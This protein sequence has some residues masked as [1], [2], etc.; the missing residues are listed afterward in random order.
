MKTATQP[1]APHHGG[2][3]RV[4][5][6][7]GKIRRHSHPPR[8]DSVSKSPSISPLSSPGAPNTSSTCPIPHI[9]CHH[10]HSGRS[11][12]RGSA[13]EEQERIHDLELWNTAYDALKRDSRAAGLVLAYESII[14]HGLP[15]TLRPGHYGN[16]NGLPAE[17]DKRL[18]LM[19]MIA[20]SGL[21]REVTPASKADSGD[22]DAREILVEARATIA[23]LVT[24]Q[25]SVS[26]AWSGICSLTPL[27]LD[28][29][30][31]H[32]DLR[33]GFVHLTDT[34]PHYMTLP[35]ALHPSSWTSPAEYQRLQ[36]HTRQTLLDLYRRL[37]EYEMN[38]VCAAASS[39]NMAARN[40]VDWQGWKAMDDAVREKDDE[41]RGD[42]EKYGTEEVKALISQKRKPRPEGG[43][44]ASLSQSPPIA[45]ERH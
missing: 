38:I 41:L 2:T 12:R 3:S 4:K 23:S 15:D 19:T 16:P 34:I 13:T 7:V 42:M 28:P 37:L 30:L 8:H 32:D 40:V 22:N 35:R 44:R 36:P 25:P 1:A 5:R 24:E 27:L 29:L 9:G 33:S 14:A 6:I 20:T 45:E 39:W 10:R 21:N 18:E 26:L 43:G 17:H 31:R 11:S